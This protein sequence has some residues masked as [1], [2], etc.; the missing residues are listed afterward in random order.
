MWQR[1]GTEDYEQPLELA[2]VVDG[3]VRWSLA[4][5]RRVVGGWV[6]CETHEPVRHRPTH[7]RLSRADC[8]C[9]VRSSAARP[10][11][12]PSVHPD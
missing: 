12:A 2:V 11:A 4:P 3:V 5:C 1:I 6:H 9:G 10:A 7:W 8:R